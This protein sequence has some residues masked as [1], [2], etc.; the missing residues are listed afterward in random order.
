MASTLPGYAYSYFLPV[1]LKQGMGYTTAQAQLL[2]AAPYVLAAFV[3]FTSGWLGDRYHIRGPIIAV[4]QLLTAVG[5]LIT[6]YGGSNGVRY[7]GAFLGLGLGFVQYCVPGIVTYQASEW[8]PI[9]R[10]LL[11][12]KVKLA[13]G[14]YPR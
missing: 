8:T 3:T 2:S 13:D 10:F 9:Q 4:H 5:M 1:I 7:F 12:C 11:A 6:A 14:T